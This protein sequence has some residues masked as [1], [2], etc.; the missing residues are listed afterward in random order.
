MPPHSHRGAHEFPAGCKGP[1][2][3]LPPVPKLDSH[4]NPRTLLLEG[5]FRDQVQPQNLLQGLERPGP[6]RP[7][8]VFLSMLRLRECQ[9]VYGRAQEAAKHHHGQS[10]AG[11]APIFDCLPP[12]TRFENQSGRV[13]TAVNRQTLSYLMRHLHACKKQHYRYTPY[14]E[15]L[16]WSPRS[17]SSTSLQRLLHEPRRF[18][19]IAAV[20]WELRT[21]PD[22][23]GSV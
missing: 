18:L 11:K 16:G 1:L 21:T 5:R 19:G 20:P 14:F 7:D 22:A 17:L 2:T 13:R 6:T 8:E 15:I 23:R 4:Q 9:G 10:I 3:L 12:S